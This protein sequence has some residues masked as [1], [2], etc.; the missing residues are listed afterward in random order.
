MRQTTPAESIVAVNR[1]V[2]PLE[3]KK[4][5]E[6]VTIYEISKILG[7]SLDLRKT[8]REVLNVLSSHM[9]MCRCMIA[10]VQD[11]GEVHIIGAT[12]LSQ[13]EINRGRFQK[14][15]GVIGKIVK[16]GIPIV[17]PHVAEE[18]RF[19]NRT[20][21]RTLS[22]GHVIAFVGIPIKIAGQTVGVLSVD[23][24]MDAY[25]SSLER[26]VRLLKMV[27]NLI[28]QTLRLHQHVAVEREQLMHEQHRLQ[29]EVRP[30]KGL[31]NVIGTS[32]SMQEVFVDVERAASVHSTVLLRGESGTGKEVI[33]NAIHQLSARKGGPFVRVNC[34]ALSETLLESE[35][36]GHEKGAFT[37]ATSERKGRFEMA[38]GGTLFLDE[39][40]EISPAFQVKLL[41][42]LQEREFERVG[43]NNT[44]RVDVRLIAATNRNLEAAVTQGEF[45]ADL[46]FRIN[47]ISIIL[48]PLRERRDDIPHLVSHFLERFNQTNER[49]VNLSPEAMQI[50]TE[51]YWP[52]NV[53]ELENCVERTA[54]MTK[55]KVI[56][57]IHLSCQRN[58]CLSMA[59]RP[60]SQI[61]SPAPKVA[62]PSSSA[63][64]S[65]ET[66]SGSRE[67]VPEIK[68]TR[69]RLIW[70]MEE[71]GWVQA[72]AARFLGMT[73]RQM[74]YALQKYNIE[75]KRL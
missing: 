15:E 74:H 41:R 4:N 55:G 11:S 33:A 26:D 13:D 52:G 27:A 14:G 39:I 57:D 48:P 47:V 22:V 2:Q 10:L 60:A 51:C 63:A 12:G 35:L 25:Q 61:A 9:D 42:V 67:E 75:I 73:T 5:L 7:S 69:E 36:F 31:V 19:L 6:L 49:Q 18:P 68:S 46:Y 32:R 29:K 70:A 45:R 43:G 66:G 21:S 20:G 72:K 53:R 37:G 17:I 54:A 23:R 50:M 64:G 65:G 38:D 24:E 1:A 3:K 58:M 62:P 16:T 28:S 71:C 8:I 56:Q 34:A 59:L 30:K 40:G 44:I